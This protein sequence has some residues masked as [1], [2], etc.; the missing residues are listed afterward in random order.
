MP[1]PDPGDLNQVP[2]LYRCWFRKALEGRSRTA[3]IKAKCLECTGYARKEVTACTART[4]SLWPY[5]PYQRGDEPEP[6][7]SQTQM[8]HHRP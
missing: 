1:S 3:A 4:C 7:L 2:L 5:R 8:R 6:T